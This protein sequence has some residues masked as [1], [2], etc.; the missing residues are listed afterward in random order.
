LLPRHVIPAPHRQKNG[1]S[2][3][4]TS[5]LELTGTIRFGLFPFTLAGNRRLDPM[6]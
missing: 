3:V 6:G 5:R 1:Y 4:K 2:E